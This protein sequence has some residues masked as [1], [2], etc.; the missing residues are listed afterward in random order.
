LYKAKTIFIFSPV[1][2]CFYASHDGA[3][4]NETGRF[5]WGKNL[6]ASTGKEENREFVTPNAATVCI[7]LESSKCM[8]TY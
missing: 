5:S 6:S 7:L 2:W 8:K 1:I 4:S 3:I